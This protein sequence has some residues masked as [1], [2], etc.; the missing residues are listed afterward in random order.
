[1]FCNPEVL[2]FF[3]PSFAKYDQVSRHKK[4]SEIY[5]K[6]TKNLKFTMKSDSK[7]IYESSTTREKVFNHKGT[8]LI[9]GKIR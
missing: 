3:V 6:I 9:C 1:M 7:D 8:W 5:V 4:V 2:L